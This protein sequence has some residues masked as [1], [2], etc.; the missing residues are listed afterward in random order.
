MITALLV[1]AAKV[2]QDRLLKL[3]VVAFSWLGW[4]DAFDLRLMD[5]IWLSSSLFSSLTRVT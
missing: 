2:Q 4:R 3:L 1:K 5:D